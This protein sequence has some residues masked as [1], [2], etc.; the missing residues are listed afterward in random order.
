[1]LLVE[2]D[3]INQDVARILLSDAGLRVD[4][5]EHGEQALQMAGQCDYALILMDMQMPVMDGLEASRYIRQ[6]PDRAN[7]PILAVSAN[8]F[9]EDREKCLAAGMSD[10]IAKPFEPDDLFRSLLK[11]LGGAKH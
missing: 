9:N 5:A 2:D 6:L 11:W 3:P 10:F 4:L 8:A 1:M 7:T